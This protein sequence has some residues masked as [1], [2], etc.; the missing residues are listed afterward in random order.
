[1]PWFPRF[2]FSDPFAGKSAK[3]ALF[4]ILILLSNAES[5]EREVAAN[6]VTAFAYIP[7]IIT[8][9]HPPKKP[10]KKN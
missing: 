9:S 7:I 1:L 10:I 5:P 8:H 4:Y 3:T 2:L 6:F